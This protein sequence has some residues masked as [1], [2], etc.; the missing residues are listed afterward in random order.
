MYEYISELLP[1]AKELTKLDSN[2]D[3]AAS[4]S[5]CSLDYKEDNTKAV[6]IVSNIT[7]EPLGITVTMDRDL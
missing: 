3:L 7:G 2:E 4:M 1:L 5:L 6:E